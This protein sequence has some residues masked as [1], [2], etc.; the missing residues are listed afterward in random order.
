[1]QGPFLTTGEVARR[2][3][4]SPDTIKRWCRSGKLQ[5]AYWLYGSR[6]KGWRIPDL[7][8]AMVELHEQQAQEYQAEMEG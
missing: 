1:M 4:L 3:G 7:A 2:L 6:Q 5:G 8:V